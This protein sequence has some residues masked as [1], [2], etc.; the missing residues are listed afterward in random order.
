MCF[1]QV[2]PSSIACLFCVFQIL[3]LESQRQRTPKLGY[4]ILTKVTWA[5]S[6][7]DNTL[8]L[9]GQRMLGPKSQGY[10]QR[11]GK[12]ASSNSPEP[13]TQA[14]SHSPLMMCLTILM[15]LPRM[16]RIW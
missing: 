4:G 16:F 14:T 9:A 5:H 12:K 2:F 6:K 13:Q 10:E 3:E 11:L 8:Q 15:E 1:Q 7:L